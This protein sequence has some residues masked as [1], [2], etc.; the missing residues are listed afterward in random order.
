LTVPIT[1]SGGAPA[2]RT[3]GSGSRGARHC[4][5]VSRPSANELPN[6]GYCLRQAVRVRC[7]VASGTFSAVSAQ[8]IAVFASARLV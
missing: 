2:A 4:W 7:T 5:Q 8:L 1:S 6:S 3:A